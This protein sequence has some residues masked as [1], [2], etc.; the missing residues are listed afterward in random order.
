MGSFAYGVSGDTSD[1]DIY[2]FCI[3]PKEVV[4]PHLAGRIIGF[5]RQVQMFDQ[6]QQ[7][8]IKYSDGDAQID[9]SIYNIVKYF[10]LCMECNP[11][12]IDSLFTP[13]KC[14]M[15]ITQ[16]GQMVRDNR[17]IFLSKAAWHKFRGYAY[18]QLHK[19]S[20]R[21]PI[22][23]RVEI[24]EEHG[25]DT[26]Y[27]YHLIRLLDEAEQIMTEGD[28]DLTRNREQLKAIR[29]GEVSE[30][31]VRKIATEKEGELEGVYSRSTLR[32]S[33]DE[34]SIKQ[35]LLSC[36]EHH[37]GSLDKC[38]ANIDANANAIKEIQE[39][40]RRHNL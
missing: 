8:H 19:M 40:L 25:F 29:R 14:V 23:K 22:G 13:A 2:G 36:L 38:V 6:F 27:A 5:G 24:I 33:P 28:I 9:L 1:C 17:K 16:V 30:D 12:M 7:H 37:Y 3:P 11:N 10:N 34:E 18:S 20:S 26:K 15:H 4:F 32:H 39:V 21:K 31:D 35:L